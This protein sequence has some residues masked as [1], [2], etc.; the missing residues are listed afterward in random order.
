MTF[1]KLGFLL[2]FTALSITAF[3]QT[4]DNNSNG[5]QKKGRRPDIPGNFVLE[6]G[7]NREMGAPDAFSLGFW[8]SRTLNVYYQ[9]DIRIA[10]S[11]FSVVPGIGVSL[12][13]F[14]FKNNRTLAYSNDS[15]KLVTGAELGMVNFKK[16]QLITNYVEIPLEIK[17]A[18]KPEDPARTFKASLGGRIGFMY[19]GF[20][21]I[22][23]KDD[24]D[25][26]KIKNKQDW[27]LNKIRYGVYAKVGVGNFSVFGYYNLTDLFESGEGPTGPGNKEAIKDF[28]TFTA[29]ISLSSF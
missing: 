28:A 29:G 23:F 6:L 19:D 22:K 15:L 16:S 12:E 26:I 25:I 2:A 7:L 13:R 20:T 18:S 3:S 8:G 27:N 17:Y 21:K 4:T 9:Y 14:K 24:S 5:D 11:R 10:K 1:Q